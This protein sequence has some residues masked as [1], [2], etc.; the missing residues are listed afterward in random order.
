MS[1]GL[2]YR[3][4]FDS[5]SDTPYEINILEAGYDG[6]VENR[7]LGSA[8]VLKMDD[9]EA[10]R[11]TSLELSIETCFDGDL[12]E[13]YTTDRKKFRVEVY[14]SGVLFWSGH[15]LPEL[16]SEPYISVP[17]DVSVTASDGLGLLKNIPFGLSGKRSVFD[18]IKYCCEQTGLVLNYVFASK[19]LA[20]GMSGVASVYTQAFVDCNAFD[21]ADCYE[22]LEKVLITFGSYIKQKDCKWH[23]LRYTDQ[24]TDLMEYDPSCNFAGGFRPVMK[25]LGAIGDD[26]YPVGQLESE[27]V[28]AR[29]DFTMEQPYELYPSLLKDY[30]FAAVGSWIL[31]P[32]V[33]FMRVDEETY[34][35][36]KPT[37]LPEKLEAY[38]MQSISVEA[39]NRPFRIEF[40]FSICLMSN[41]EIGSIDMST[42]R[43]FR[44]EIFITDSGG[45]RHYLSAEGWGTK[46]TYIEVRGDV[47][48]GKLRITDGV[49]YDYIPASFETFRINL[50]RIPYSGEMAFRII[51]PYK[52]YTVPGTPAFDDYNDMNIICLKEFV[53]TSD[54]DGNPDV[55]V[56]LNPE[57]S[58]SAPSLKVGFVDAPFTE[59]AQ[60][61]FKNILMTS[62]GFTSEWYCR[63]S[64]LDSFANIALQDM[65]S[66]IGVPSFCL[67]GVIHATDFDLL[68]DKYSGRKLYLKEY[69]YDLMEEEIDCTLCELLPFNA[70]IDGEITQSPRSSNKSK[71]ETRASGETEYR[72][73]GGTISTPKM[74]RELVSMPDDQLSE[75]CLL[76]VDDRMSVSSKRVAVGG[77]TD[78]SYK[79]VLQSGVFWT[80]EEMNCTDGYLEVQ[81]EKI[82]AGDSDKWNAHEFDD[83]LDQPVRKTDSVQ[84]KQVTADKITTDEIISDNFVSGPL[85]EGMNLI[86]R[87]SSGKSYLE[88]DKIFARYKAVFAALE[89]RKLTY[90]GGNYI[91]SPA[92]ATCTMVEDKEGFYRCYFTADDGEKAV[93]NL[94]RTD[95]FVQCRESNIK[96]GTYENISNRYYWRRCIATGDDYIDLSKSDCDTDSDIPAIGDSMV[97]IGNKTVSTR[98]NAII[99]SVY[100]EG[101]PS[102]I[103]YKGINTFSLEGKAKIIISPDQNR[104]T[105]KFTFETGE[106]AEESIGNIQNNLDNLQVGETNLLDNSNKG[107]KNTGYP[108]ATI[109]L[110]DYKP[111]QGEEC[112]IVIKG[113]LGANKTSWGVYNSGGNVVLASFYPGGPDTDY[114]ALKT[115][116]WTLGTPAVDNTFI[117]IYPIPDNEINEE[118]EI[119]WVKLVLGNK[120]SLLWTPSIN[121]Q[122]QIAT[123]IAQAKA[124]LAETRANAYA[125]GIVTEAEQNAINEAQTRLDALQIGSQNLISKKMMLKWNEKNKNIAVWGQ[126][127][128]GVYLRI[129]EVLL[130]K[131]WAGSNEIANPVFDLQFKPD[132]QYVLSVE[133]KLAA[134]QNY[135]GLAF[136]IFYTDGTAEWH[137]LA[138][139]IITK[140][141]A[142]LITK[143]GKTVQKISA[144]YGSSKAN[145]LIYNISLIEGNK[146]LQGF[147]V[148]EEDQTGANN[149]NLADGTKEFTL[150]VGSTNYTYKE[151]YVSKIKPNTVY[152]VNAGNI[153]NLVGNPDRYSFVLYNKDISTVLCPTLNADKNGG[154]LITYNNFTE[155]E[156]RLLCYAGIAGSTLGNSVKFTEVMLVEGFLPAPVWAPSFSEQ[157][158]EIKTITKTLTEIK[159]ENG[160]I[161]LRVNEVSERVEEA[162]QEAIDT[163]NEYATLKS[164]RETWI[165]LTAEKWNRDMYY[166]VTIKIDV[167]I[168]TRI[169]VDTPLDYVNVSW[170]THESGGYS[171]LCAWTV[172][173]SGWGSITVH[174]VIESSQWGWTEL[175]PSSPDRLK[176]PFGSI[177]QLTNNN[178][179]Y[180]LLRGGGKY[181]F[182]IT[183]NCVPI[184]HNSRYT[185]YGGQHVDPQSSV[186]GP[187]LTNATKEELNAEINITKGLI[188]NKVS[189]D[190]YNENDQ[191]IKSD[192][193]NL[194][195]SYNQI[196]ST[197]SKIINGTQE[198]SGVVTQSNF[199]TIFSSN[200][201]ALGQEV[202]ESINVGGG[203]V[204]IDASRI[205]L[206]GAISA[207]GNVQ[208]TTDGKLIAVNGEFTGKI[209]ATEGEIAG[210]KLS[211]NGLRSS[212][213]NA[214]SKIGSCYAKNGFSV[215]AS[216]SGVLAPSTGMLQA[217]IITATGDNA[218][219][220]GLEIIAKNTSSYATL[221]KITALKLRA[222][223]Y[224]DDSKKM[225][226]TAALIV[227]EGVSIFN[228]D[229]EVNG[230]S[231]FNG[232]VY[233]KN[234]QNVNGKKNYYLCIDRSTGQLYYR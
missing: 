119:E 202:I 212:D 86:R 146:P 181:R 218:E 109:Y 18:V 82:K 49:N 58:T 166:P 57:A 12:R 78:L 69:S 213:F 234:V 137:G 110:G 143:A 106:D 216:G 81:G 15:I 8:P 186:I 189:L 172:N 196:S 131:N 91:F 114:I 112:T 203:G 156:G 60:G 142:R 187:V 34:C 89:I 219:I 130:H 223:D 228:G 207:N 73:Y 224:V 198:I 63:G 208:I 80:K 214:S 42:G 188:E 70:G 201:N 47:Q 233:F 46:E 135:D 102:F 1:Y 62:G 88:I 87:D 43:S 229:V 39:C 170:G 100:G 226:P 195:V 28:P 85:G 105:G 192:I 193:S 16:Y 83:F 210:L 164:Y 30:C 159:A 179:E 221:A 161:S 20:T 139:T 75:G 10:V 232:A 227:E 191:L 103:Q 211:N 33:R 23:V 215:Y 40:Q 225:A 174:R 136:R 90:A 154:F 153:Q 167:T 163:A 158:A 230:K 185:V 197:V 32:G 84:F 65:S 94:F 25:T 168:K 61:I 99:I 93:E 108:I 177:G 178:E 11:G 182:R 6:P 101:S 71:T 38:V 175:D 169:Q 220:I 183:N 152:Y 165:D 176:I 217:G 52:Y 190:V 19:L 21:D 151:L 53:F 173:G 96:S 120:T 29:K 3:L 51:N 44:L 138:G 222:I 150:G 231:T 118:S 68:S 117:R 9:G 206:N 26:T 79:R 128:D 113:K 41:R 56:L 149:V 14:R 205:N 66:R 121:D 125:D 22:A 72:S 209:T 144:S 54:V 35:E 37:K 2:K 36:L 140:T 141:I 67:H 7:N 155:Q 157:Q 24:D 92:G 17:F 76:E 48:N 160:E 116:K 95:D 145:T 4:S 126:D 184:E 148:A 5:V 133:W 55:N 124:D 162:K 132:T 77:L 13:F 147:P 27:I 122:K 107:W 115:F 104:F 59:N 123:D 180:I 64:G 134:V 74:I 171:M 97:T 194:Q 199:V 50:E 98:Q 127:A 129:N 45:T 31:S 204:T 111:K 200:K